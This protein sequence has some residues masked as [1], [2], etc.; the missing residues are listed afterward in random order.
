[1]PLIRSNHIWLVWLVTKPSECCRNSR[2]SIALL[3][4][5]QQM[6][7]LAA[8]DLIYWC[9]TCCILFEQFAYYTLSW[10]IQTKNCLYR[11]STFFVINIQ[12]SA[13]SSRNHI[14]I[15][16]PRLYSIMYH[17]YYSHQLRI[18]KTSSSCVT[19]KFSFYVPNLKIKNIAVQ[20]DCR[21]PSSVY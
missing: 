8:H 11:E 20:K 21:S 6:I 2:P 18:L 17:Y 15:T 16:S 9:N 4:I 3:I 19:K 13:E 14:F 12:N 7:W 10:Q 5:K 1:M